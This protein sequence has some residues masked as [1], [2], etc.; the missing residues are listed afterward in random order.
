MIG[1]IKATIKEKLE[2]KYTEEEV[3]KAMDDFINE[4]WEDVPADILKIGIT[5]SYDMGWNKRSTGKVYDSLSGHAF[6]I[7]CRT[8]NVIG[9]MVKKR[10]AA[11]AVS[12]TKTKIAHQKLRTIFRLILRELVERWRQQLLWN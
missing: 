9:M 7:G 11:F 12:S 4:K 8:G 3:D 5:V 1:E 6:I 10:N 2:G